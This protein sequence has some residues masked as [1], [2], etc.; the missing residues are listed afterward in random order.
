MI[1]RSYKTPSSTSNLLL[2]LKA[3]SCRKVSYKAMNQVGF[4]HAVISHTLTL[5]LALALAQDFILSVGTAKPDKEATIPIPSPAQT[6]ALALRVIVFI[7]A[8]ICSRHC[9]NICE[10]IRVI[11]FI[12][13]HIAFMFAS[14]H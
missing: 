3:V 12:Y 11:V 9:I 6:L 5:A 14:L 7:Y 8:N 4:C 13:A 2:S 10:Y 1:F